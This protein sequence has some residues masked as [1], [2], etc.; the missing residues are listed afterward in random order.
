M[1]QIEEIGVEMDSDDD[2]AAPGWE[3]TSRGSFHRGNYTLSWV[4]AY[5][6]ADYPM[7]TD[8]VPEP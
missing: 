4:K 5:G 1:W 8:V 6:T 7:F 3:G 2:P